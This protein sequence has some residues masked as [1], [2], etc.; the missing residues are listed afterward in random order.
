MKALNE[1]NKAELRA[2]CKAVGVKGYGNMDNATMR[3]AIENARIDAELVKMYGTCNCPSCNAHLSNG[4]WDSDA[5]VESHLH[6]GEKQAA[7]EANQ[8]LDKK[9][10]CMACDECF[11]E[12]RVPMDLTPKAKAAPVATGIKIE[13]NR[14]EQ[15]GIK[16][17]SAGGVCRAIWDAAANFMEVNKR[18]P[19]LKEMKAIATEN[20]WDLTTTSIQYYTWRKFMGI[21]GRV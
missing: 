11:G 16:R 3:N 4:V 12:D 20:Q 17:P 14:E 1:M 5:L 15:N 2:E 10:W 19:K 8:Q 7:K 18:C 9:F 13:K 21:E 6:N